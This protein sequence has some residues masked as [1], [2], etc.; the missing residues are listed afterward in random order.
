MFLNKRDQSGAKHGLTVAGKGEGKW[1][2]GDSNTWHWGF[3]AES[4]QKPRWW[5]LWLGKKFISTWYNILSLGLLWA[6]YR[7][8]R[9]KYQYL[10]KWMFHHPDFAANHELVPQTCCMTVDFYL[11]T[12]PQWNYTFIEL[13]VN[14][15]DKDQ[16]RIQSVFF[17]VK[18]L[19]FRFFCFFFQKILNP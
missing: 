11:Q 17:F 15:P 16:S 6:G 9:S 3:R 1:V 10:L 5:G 12:M 18:G 2:A 4:I 19:S 8:I 14:A 13:H 7:A